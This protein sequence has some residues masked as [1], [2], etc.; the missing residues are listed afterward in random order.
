MQSILP[1]LPFI[2][3]ISE[4]NGF[5]D[6]DGDP[7]TPDPLP[8]VV[9]RQ[10]AA[11]GS[12]DELISLVD[13][14]V[15]EE[16][17][18]DGNPIVGGFRYEGTADQAAENSTLRIG[19]VTTDTALVAL[20]K[21]FSERW[22]T[23]QTE[24]VNPRLLEYFQLLARPDADNSDA[25]TDLNAG[26][27]SFDPELH[28]LKGLVDNL[29]YSDDLHV[30]VIEINGVAAAAQQLARSASTIVNS[31]VVSGTT[32]SIVTSL[33]ETTNDHYKSRVIIFTSGA[34]QNQ[35]AEVTAYNGTTKALTVSALTEAPQSGDTFILV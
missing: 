26:G 25:L 14:E 7:Y 18:L 3:Q 31:S 32:T 13:D 11:D 24:D 17:F 15:A 4:S 5:V 2:I 20:G 21:F 1:N 12:Y 9:V 6:A 27:G 22:V 8:R 35:V 30:D 29:A 33:T 19:F 10:L 34:L 23:L 28:S 16:A